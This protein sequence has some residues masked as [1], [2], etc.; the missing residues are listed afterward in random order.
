MI[1]YEPV[2]PVQKLHFIIIT[3][4][5]TGC[6]LGSRTFLG[7]DSLGDLPLAY[8]TPIVAGLRCW[9]I[10]FQDGEERGKDLLREICLVPEGTE[11]A[12]TVD[13]LPG[14]FILETI[15]TLEILRGEWT[16][17]TM[18]VDKC[19]QTIEDVRYIF[20]APVSSEVPGVFAPEGTLGF[21]RLGISPEI[22]PGGTPIE[23]I[24]RVDTAGPTGL[25]A[26]PEDIITKVLKET[27]PMNEVEL[28]IRNV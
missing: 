12:S 14:D 13:K 5:Q 28:P 15:K 23:I 21:C 8:R 25:F 20:S 17:D 4:S 18:V 2:K 27:T 24:R 16:Y 22:L 9:E 6:Q 1:K 3:Q 11:G 10:I 26:S 19:L 7:L